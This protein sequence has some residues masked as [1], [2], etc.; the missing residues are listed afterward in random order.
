MSII[1]QPIAKPV[2]RE[3]AESCDQNEGRDE[4]DETVAATAVHVF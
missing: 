3:G 4:G 1:V 2:R